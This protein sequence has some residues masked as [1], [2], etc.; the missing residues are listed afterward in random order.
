MKPVRN[1]TAVFFVLAA[2]L[3]AASVLPARAQYQP[4]RAAVRAVHGSATFSIGGTWQP[5]KENTPLT[6]G[7]IIKTA[8]DTTLDLFLPDSRTVLRLMP[9]SV[10]RFDRMD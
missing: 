3:L 7:A 2:S 4:A 10:L 5:L 9:D 6:A 1:L 8:P